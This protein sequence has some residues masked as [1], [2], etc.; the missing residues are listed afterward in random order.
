VSNNRGSWSGP[1]SLDEAS[2]R[3]GGRR[4]YNRVRRFLATYRRYQ[5]ARLLRDRGGWTDWGTQARLARELG[6]SRS[7]ICR[8]VAFLLRESR[9]C[10]CCGALKLPEPRNAGDF[11][12]G[13]EITD[14]RGI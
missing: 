5:L 11:T 7:T 3:A 4:R 12:D 8:D 14:P 6:V 9:P 13:E 10:P 2:R 1:T